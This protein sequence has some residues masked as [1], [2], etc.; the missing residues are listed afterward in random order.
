MNRRRTKII[1]TLGPATDDINVLSQIIQAGVDVVRLN[2]SH[3]D[4]H[5]LKRRVAD[6]RHVC[7]QLGEMVAILGDL[8]GPKIRI[9]RFANGP[10][11][12][13]K[14]Q[15]F[16]LNADLNDEAGSQESV[17]I[18]YKA[19]PK[20]VKKDDILLLN[21]GCIELKVNH[22][23][24]NQINT[25]V[26][27]GGPLSNNKGINLK[28]GGLSAK[29]LTDKD[30]KDIATAV[31]LD[32]D[33][34]ALSF[35]RDASDIQEARDVLA[36]LNSSMAIIAKI[37][38]IEAMENL[39]AIIKAADGCMVARGD[40][41]V[42]IGDAEVPTAQRLIIN[43]SRALNKPVITATQMMES[44][45]TSS[46]PT[47]AEVSDVANA[48]LECTD[49]VMLSAESAVGEHPIKVV[50]AMDRVCRAAEKNPS[51]MMSQHR[52][53]CTFERRD[54]AVA[55]ATMYVANHMDIKCI[56]AL[57]ESGATPLWMSRI[58][59]GIPIIGL[60][61]H[62]KTCRLMMLY[63]SVF[64][65]QFDATQVDRVKLNEAALEKLLALGLV[66]K[67][68]LV[69]ITKGSLMGSHGGTC[70]LRIARV[71]ETY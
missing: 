42:E 2:F 29:A 14:G 63:R 1:A 30:R 56:V 43:T 3:G 36:K 40:L 52:V 68:D 11:E 39:D 31:D 15:D 54:E 9:A 32:L 13:H 34:L 16:C 47:R 70:T 8:Q 4:S 62:V 10:I 37:E 27:T 21:D 57:T 33:Y 69:I 58:R 38:R 41:A 51:T 26:V 5:V 7:E 12:L 65:V 46:V 18:D 44:M 17:G 53:D 25:T 50:E 66:K 59:S 60:S 71:G 23:K 64:P 45:I 35:P 22:V 28:G 61:R 6:V 49:A 19:L 24:G 67:D 20:D 55:M 48:V